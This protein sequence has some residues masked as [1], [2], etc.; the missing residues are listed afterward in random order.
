MP[1][2]PNGQNPRALTTAVSPSPL[3]GRGPGRFLGRGGLARSHLKRSP[4]GYPARWHDE[5][6]P[7]LPTSLPRA[8]ERSRTT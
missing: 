1:E 7:S 4:W 6:P 2:P 8:G 3:R 5:R